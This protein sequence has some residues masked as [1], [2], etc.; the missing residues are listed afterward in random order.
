M[1]NNAYQ[2]LSDGHSAKI[3]VVDCNIYIS[4]WGKQPNDCFSPTPTTKVMAQKSALLKYKKTKG[5]NK[6]T[7]GSQ[8]STNCTFYICCHRNN[9]SEK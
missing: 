4:D 1:K 5:Y 6:V 7:L 9:L 2:S 8:S 3:K